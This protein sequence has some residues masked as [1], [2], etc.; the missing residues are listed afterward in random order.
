MTDTRLYST[1]IRISAYYSDSKLDRLP[2]STNYDKHLYDPDLQF[3]ATLDSVDFIPAVF[4]ERHVLDPSIVA[5][6]IIVSCCGRKCARY[7]Y[8]GLP[9]LGV[10]RPSST[11]IERLRVFEMYGF[12]SVGR[13]PPPRG[14]KSRID[15]NVFTSVCDI[16]FARCASGTNTPPEEQWAVARVNFRATPKLVLRCR[17]RRRPCYFLYF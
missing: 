1:Q 16:T 9:I 11:L 15:R 2:P 14:R 13:C 4:D 7:R 8:I 17:L 3:V 5:F 10:L 12:H 6:K